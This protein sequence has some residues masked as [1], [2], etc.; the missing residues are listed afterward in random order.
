MEFTWP[1]YKHDQHII[2][3]RLLKMIKHYYYLNFKATQTTQLHILI[4]Q[5]IYKAN[6]F[7]KKNSAPSCQSNKWNHKKIILSKQVPMLLVLLPVH[8]FQHT[9]LCESM[10]ALIWPSRISCMSS[11]SKAPTLVL[12]AEAIL[13]MSADRYGLKYWTH[14]NTCSVQPFTLYLFWDTYHLLPSHTT[15]KRTNQGRQTTAF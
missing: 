7:C 9:L 8:P 15:K 13:C 14:H 4:I 5:I 12:N 10:R 11:S 2:P 6:R 3:L 1:Q